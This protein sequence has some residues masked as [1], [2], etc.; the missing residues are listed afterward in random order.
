M[1]YI[2]Q[3][4]SNPPW[5]IIH[6]SNLKFVHWS[7]KRY[8]ERLIRENFDYSGTPIKFSFRDEKQIKEN[9]ARISA[10]KKVINKASG[11]LKKATDTQNKR[12]RK[13]DEKLAR[14]QKN[15]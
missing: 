8:L 14:I 13:R 3:S 6:G 9:R 5:F 4:D 10:G 2:S 1:R 7:Y 15:Q 11:A 12:E